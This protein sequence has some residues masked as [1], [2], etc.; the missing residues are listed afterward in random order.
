MKDDE[1]EALLARA[2]NAGVTLQELV[3]IILKDELATQ[4][5]NKPDTAEVL[6]EELYACTNGMEHWGKKYLATR[7][8]DVLAEFDR[9][10]KWSA[11]I[12]AK[13]KELGNAKS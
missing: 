13:I 1:I 10:L 6:L 9:A 7:D 11:E 4:E 5:W 2:G 12:R 3:Y 8:D